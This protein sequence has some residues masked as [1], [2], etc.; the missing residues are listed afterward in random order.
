MT[1]FSVFK[2][3]RILITGSTGFK[4]SWLSAW[5]ADLGASVTGL[6]LP[7]APDAPLFDQL[8]LAERIDQHFIDIRHFD[9]VAEL[10]DQ[11]K[12]EIIIHL[13]AQAL[14]RRSYAEPLET[15]HTN[16]TGGINL[17]EA[18]RH[19]P[20]VRSLVFIT[21]DKCYRNM[22][23]ERGYHEDDLLGGPDPY[24]ASKGAV[25]L[26]FSGYQESFFRA[27]AGLVA[28]TARAGNV[29]GG[30]DMSMDRIVPDCIRALRAGDP[31]IL[32]NPMATRPWQHVLE[33]LSG[34]LALA[35]RQFTGDDAAAGAWNFGPD[36]ENV[37]PVQDLAETA[38]DVWGS[39]DVRV[40]QD[41][42]APHEATL[43]MLDSTKAKDGL[44][45]YPRWDFATG[46]T[47]TVEWYKAVDGGADPI[48]VTRAQTAEY[49]KADG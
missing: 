3:R 42:N 39:G 21:S 7:P 43:L 44:G 15:F 37:R 28:A 49:E 9:P 29:I 45:W 13:A 17:L 40:E 30:G 35:A 32:R 26:V 33:P 10:L 6:A 27:R 19:T 23:W 12:P 46:I 25:E 47:R 14:V 2:N 48:E 5:L 1:D 34:Y 36:A 31:V 38:V 24:S 8:R 20:S 41:P 18:V 11:S 16:V 22:E 4:G